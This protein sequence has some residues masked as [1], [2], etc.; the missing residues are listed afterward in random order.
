MT[1]LLSLL[2]EIKVTR[3]I[4][5]TMRNLLTPLTNLAGVLF[6]IFYVFALVGMYMFGGLVTKNSQAIINDPTIP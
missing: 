1:K 5:E 6:T 4:M 2:Y 3:V